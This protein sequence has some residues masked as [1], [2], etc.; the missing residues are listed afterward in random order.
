M[1]K[2]ALFWQF[3]AHLMIDMSYHRYNTCMKV[4][5]P[6]PLWDNSVKRYECSPILVGIFIKLF[7]KNCS[8]HFHRITML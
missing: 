5:F 6:L 4:V 7:I 3:I 8:K 2:Y 1:T